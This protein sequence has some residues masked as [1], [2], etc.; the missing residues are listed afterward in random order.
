MSE[1]IKICG[2]NPKGRATRVK[3]AHFRAKAREQCDPNEAKIEIHRS[4][5]PAP[6]DSGKARSAAGIC[7]T[8]AV[9]LD[10][11]KKHLNISIK[12]PVSEVY[13]FAS[14]PANLPQWASGLAES[15]LKKSVSNSK[16]S[17]VIF[18]LYRLPRHSEEELAKDAASIQKDLKK[19]KS[20][21]EA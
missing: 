8:S 13:A 20:L 18:T 14:N 11:H 2:P 5:V 15:N 21:L 19:L 12:R 3:Q 10:G 9:G 1:N 16:G 17:E 4:K 7:K 6:H